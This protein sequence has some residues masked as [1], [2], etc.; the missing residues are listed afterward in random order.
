ME[1]EEAKIE[2]KKFSHVIDMMN[3][4][5]LPGFSLQMVKLRLQQE[6]VKMDNKSLIKSK[7][8]EIKFEKFKNLFDEV[9]HHPMR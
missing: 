6:F 3:K 8:E 2:H 9:V 4:D 1:S 5:G 7:N